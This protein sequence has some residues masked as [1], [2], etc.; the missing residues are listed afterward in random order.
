M[1]FIYKIIDIF[2]K[3]V[4]QSKENQW[5]FRL[6]DFSL[7]TRIHFFYITFLCIIIELIFSALE[8]FSFGKL[9]KLLTKGTFDFSTI[10]YKL[11]PMI[12][13][14]LSSRISSLLKDKFKNLFSLNYR[15]NLRKE[16]YTSVLG[17]DLEFFDNHK[18]SDLF[19]ILTHDIQKVEYASI[20]GLIDVFKKIIQLLI[21]IFMLFYLSMKL[22][23]FLCIVIPFVGLLESMKKNLVLGEEKKYTAKKK[24]SHFIVLEALDN[25]RIIKSFSTEDKEI[26]KY[27]KKLQ[28]M[29]DIEYHGEM[30]CCLY[31]CGT[32]ALIG[33]ILFFGIKYGL[34]LVRGNSLD[35]DTFISFF[36]YCKSILDSFYNIANSNRNFLK[37]QLFAEKIFFVLDYEP[38]IKSF[39]PKMLENVNKKE[40]MNLNLDYGLEKKIDGKIT[41]KNIFFEYPKEEGDEIVRIIKNINLEI[42][43]GMKIGIV[44][45]SG[46]G[47]STVINLIERLYD[48][49]FYERK[50]S[51]KIIQEKLGKKDKDK[52]KD[53]NEFDDASSNNSQDDSDEEKKHLKNK[54]EKKK[55]NKHKNKQ[56]EKEKL[57]EEKIKYKNTE[58]ENNIIKSEDD[59][60]VFI[61][62]INIKK[63]NIKSLHSQIGY[64]P[65]EP[66]LFDGT[67]RENVIYG[68]FD[69]ENMILNNKDPYEKELKWSLHT[70]Q[71]DFVY[72]ENTFPL[73]LNTIVGSKGAKLSGGQKQR[74]AIARALI[75]KPKI[76]ILDE[77]TSA[78]DSESESKFQLELDNLKGKMTIIV[79]SHRLCTIKDCDQIVVI[80]KGQIVEKG[81]HDELIAIKG[82]YYSLMEKQLEKE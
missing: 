35:I 13:I 27:D 59:C 15:L 82:I 52:D 1:K 5:V 17:K 76:L 71:A 42:L 8:P 79:V 69:D 38:K 78:L 7:R 51:L 32:L 47:K 49:G 63:Y 37:A 26:K 57:I 22:S 30:T 73:G 39:Y 65:Q 24:K 64:V 4:Y 67:I 28:Q 46:S 20:L 36:L 74:I 70:A 14:I 6:W 66:S 23:I 81:N 80:N 18:S 34:Y 77:A 16:Y 54:K 40:K 55:E 29:L 12:L 33:G 56:N 50:K 44:G 62:D 2:L 10:Q 9:S 75:K 53:K 58:N 45:F 43:P 31:E 48:V 25:M 11:L 21:S 68:L 61:D 3:I 60:A 72:D 19:Y 41:L